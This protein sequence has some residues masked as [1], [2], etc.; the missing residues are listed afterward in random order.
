MHIS[1]LAV[2]YYLTSRCDKAEE[3]FSRFIALSKEEEMK[4]YAS[5]LIKSCKEE[6]KEKPYRIGMTIG[7][8]YDSNVMVEPSNPVVREERKS[9]FRAVFFLDA[10]AT[11]F[12][13]QVVQ[14]A[15]D[16]NFYQ[17]IQMHLNDF[18]IHY[19]QIA[20]R[21]EIALS[22][23]VIPSVGYSLEY[24]LMGGD[25][26]ARVHTYYGEVTV[27][28]GEKL[29]TEA[30]YEYFDLKYWD[31]D[32]FSANSERS[33]YQNTVGVK[34]KFY[35]RSVTGTLYFFGDFGDGGEMFT[36]KRLIILICLAVILV[37]TPRPV[38]KHGA[39][40]GIDILMHPYIPVLK[41][42]DVRGAG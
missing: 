8:Q 18:N 26:Y 19:H 16:Y 40:F 10:G 24:E 25:L 3:F 15:V 17:S 21:L 28:E 31:S 9:D 34:Q 38:L 14:L 41:N 12:K 30:L 20:P 6:V 22:D 27:K 4:R 35:L 42:G 11:L 39:F 37:F 23:K 36:Q 5:D 2:F 33:G 7:Y 13:S 32:V 29:S 1:N